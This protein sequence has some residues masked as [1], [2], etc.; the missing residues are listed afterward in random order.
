MIPKEYCVSL[1]P[2]TKK[3][4]KFWNFT[5]NKEKFSIFRSA[6]YKPKLNPT[7]PTK[8]PFT[9]KVNKSEIIEA[10]IHQYL[11][12]EEDVTSEDTIETECPTE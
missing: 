4:K 2:E 12:L 1:T 7:F 3:T 10:L 9:R 8:P 6:R 11:T 5:P